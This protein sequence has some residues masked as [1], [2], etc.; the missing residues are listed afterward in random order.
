MLQSPTKHFNRKNVK[1]GGEGES[2]A[3]PPGGMEE[4]G[5]VTI[6]KGIDRGG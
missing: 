1:K 6:D 5:M 4:G 3:K 2:L